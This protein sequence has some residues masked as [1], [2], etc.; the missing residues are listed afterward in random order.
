MDNLSQNPVSTPPSS[1]PLA[2]PQ[3]PISP[4]QKKPR[5]PVR[6]SSAVIIGVVYLFVLI[7]FCSLAIIG[8]NLK[9]DTIPDAT[10][11]AESGTDG[12]SGTFSA[13]PKKPDITFQGKIFSQSYHAKDDNIEL[14]EF[15]QKGESSDSWTELITIMRYINASGVLPELDRYAEAVKGSVESSGGLIID[16][17]TKAD[18]VSNLA[19]NFLVYTLKNPEKKSVEVDFQKFYIRG[20]QVLSDTYSINI[21]GETMEE[22][23]RKALEFINNSDKNEIRDTMVRMSLAENYWSN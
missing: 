5:G 15:L 6:I 1:A 20:K 10:K 13:S 18:D 19:Q 2:T 16:A 3:P 17:F 11:G 7:I 23:G 12:N 9:K 8:I 22:A 21:D 4:M 14:Y